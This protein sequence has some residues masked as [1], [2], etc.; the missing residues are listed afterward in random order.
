MHTESIKIGD[1]VSHKDHPDTLCIVLSDPEKFVSIDHLFSRVF[2]LRYN[3]DVCNRP[4]NL[5]SENLVK[6]NP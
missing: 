3:G 4:L 1:L 6:I 5:I 2:C